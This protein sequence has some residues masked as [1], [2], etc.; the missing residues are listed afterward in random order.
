MNDNVYKLFEILFN[1]HEWICHE[2]VLLSIISKEMRNLVMDSSLKINFIIM[3]QNNNKRFQQIFN[4]LKRNNL[5]RNVI[6]VNLFNNGGI[7]VI[8][9]IT[10]EEL[11]LQ[12]IV[13]VDIGNNLLGNNDDLAK[14]LS[15]CPLTNLEV[16]NNNFNSGFLKNL[17]TNT[18]KN[19]SNLVLFN[20]SY[21]KIGVEGAKIIA[22][23]LLS[24]GKLQKL[25]I[26]NCSI[27]KEGAESIA[28]NIG[29][30]TGLT[31]LNVSFN[32]I[33]TKVAIEFLKT[34]LV[35]LNLRNNSI[36][37]ED[38][39]FASKLNCLT[40]LKKLNLAD[41]Y[42]LKPS[43]FGEAL[44][45]LELLNLSDVGFN[46]EEDNTYNLASILAQNTTLI[47]LN[48]SGNDIERDAAEHIIFSLNCTNLFSL[49]LSENQIDDGVKGIVKYCQ[50]KFLA[51]KYLDTDD[52]MSWEKRYS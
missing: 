40:R 7:G 46:D 23:Q 35:S 4:S 14:R 30:C 32:D 2:I 27:R 20:I 26:C 22:S 6:S 51:L 18:K 50:E 21:N 43:K 45:N 9:T 3:H 38:E 19:F 5:F 16:N 8:Q 17:F 11:N 41:N 37:D 52:N 36:R 34:G 47:D 29:Q 39:E 1:V 33:G 12:N 10:D 42:I 13:Y 49:D 25:N 44:K 28:S 15:L 48:L 31:S 24:L